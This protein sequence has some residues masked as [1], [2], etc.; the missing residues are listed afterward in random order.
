MLTVMKVFLEYFPSENDMEV[1]E[2]TSLV[3]PSPSNN[4]GTKK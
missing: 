2:I 4:F 1:Y 3:C